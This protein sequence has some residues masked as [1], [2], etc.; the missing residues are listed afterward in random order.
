MTANKY[1]KVLRTAFVFSVTMFILC[2]L[3][4]PLAMTGISQV[5]FPKQANGSLVYQD[6]QAVGSAIVGQTFADERFMKSRPS[7]V[8]Y[9]VYTS[10]DKESGEYGGVASG[11]NNFSATNP[12][13]GERVQVD[14]TEFLAAN[15]HVKKGEIPAD[16]LTAS[17]SGLDPHIS[18]QSAKIQL[19]TIAKNTGLSTSVLEGIVKNNTNGKVLGVFGEET[20]NVLGVNMEIAKALNGMR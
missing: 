7:A 11:S 20:V 2:G 17:G 12:E 9:N 10:Q 4:Y 8:N 15:P 14:V 3:A 1:L 19:T 13:L 5:L 6:G 16:L 18:P